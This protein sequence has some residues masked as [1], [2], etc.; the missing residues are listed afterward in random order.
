MKARTLGACALLVTVALAGCATPVVSSATPASSAPL[1]AEPPSPTRAP[2]N[3]A[4]KPPP[5][6]LHTS[7]APEPSATR[8]SGPAPS[9]AFTPSN[10]TPAADPS[11]AAV[12]GSAWIPRSSFVGAAPSIYTKTTAGGSMGLMLMSPAALS[13]RFIPGYA[14]PEGSPIQAIDR[15]PSTWTPR[16][17][18]AFNGGFKLKD[19]VGGYFYNGVTVRPLR[20]GLA[21]LVI[22]S[23]GRISVIKWGRERSSVHGVTVV[24]QNLPMLV[25]NGRARATASDSNSAWGFANGNTRRA[26]RSALGQLRNGWLIYEFG[27][28]VTAKAMADSLVRAGARTAIMLDMNMSQPAGFYYRHANGSIKGHRVHPSVVDP[29]TIYLHPWDKDFIVAVAKP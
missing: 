26:N 10:T 1:T 20:T 21:S 25:D 27:H 17:V 15:R 12:A 8:V 24:R 18:A 13:F 23:Q 19:H 6:A 14:Y 9:T 16:L 28:D 29:A 11:A 22:D 3:A 4:T 5:S 2:A 7:M